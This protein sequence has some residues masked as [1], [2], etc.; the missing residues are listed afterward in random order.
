[1]NYA[2]DRNFM[3][4]TQVILS[5][6]TSTPAPQPTPEVY[7]EGQTGPS[8]NCGPMDGTQDDSHPSDE[9]EQP[10]PSG[11]EVA[12]PAV[13]TVNVYDSGCTLVGSLRFSEYP[14]FEHFQ[15]KLASRWEFDDEEN[16]LFWGATAEEV[17]L[18]VAFGNEAD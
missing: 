17:N 6:S 4:E 9:R 16:I 18:G 10:R 8:F 11:R 14:A 3:I 15:E 1:M 12:V 5:V 2:G 7:E 13:L